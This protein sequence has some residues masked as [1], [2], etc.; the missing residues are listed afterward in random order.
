[1]QTQLMSDTTL[2]V[3]RIGKNVIESNKTGIYTHTCIWIRFRMKHFMLQ[4]SLVLLRFS[5]F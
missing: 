5:D 2:R 1:M 3:K 4:K